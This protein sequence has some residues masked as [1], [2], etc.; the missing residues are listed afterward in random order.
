M[1]P[2]QLLTEIPSSL[3]QLA[4]LV[5]R[6]FYDIEYSLIVDMLVRY[7]CMR[8]DDLC[9]LLKFDKKML[10]AKLAT[11]KIDKFIV[12][13]LKIET[14]E[15]G[16]AIKMNCWFINY[17]IFVNIVKYKLDHMRKKME[18]EER[19]ATSRSSFKCTSCEKQFT[20]LEADQLFDPMSG[21]FKCTF[22]GSTVD[23]D[24]AAMPKKD[25]RLLLA[26]F[27]EQMEKLYDLLRMVEDIKLAPEVLEPD[28]VDFFNNEAGQ[29]KLLAEG[30]GTGEGREWSGEASRTGGFAVDEQMLNIT[31]GE[32]QNKKRETKE[33]PTWM[34]ES[35]VAV[36]EGSSS[37]VPSMGPAPDLLQD[38][39][40]METNT[41]DDEINNLLLRHEKRPN[42]DKVVIPGDDSDS[43]N[44][45]DDSDVEPTNDDEA[46]L[47]A[48]T[49]PVN[50]KDDD[51]EV[52]VMDDDSDENDD[53]PTINV[54][55]EDYDLTD[56]TPDVIAKMSPEEMEKY[57]QLYQDFYKDMYD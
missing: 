12:V 2:Q 44:R 19:D 15:D 50:E 43:D 22:C 18:T 51:D 14:G 33:V 48:A 6:G 13:K 38:D 49:F 36:A 32:E 7:H 17:K 57:N 41:L 56:V 37:E 39:E 45:S 35:T 8:E 20:D 54:G 42:K 21:E 16:K 53:I 27:N 28:P 25:S 9:D 47:L 34:T 4:R 29:K 52:E 23:E 40:V 26:K 30:G 5:A 1:Q 46:A 10:R 55:G 24:E 3:K 31:F 11:L